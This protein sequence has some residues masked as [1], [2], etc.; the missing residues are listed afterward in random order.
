MTER[1]GLKKTDHRKKNESRW[2]HRIDGGV[3]RLRQEVNFLER[4]VKGDLGL[5]KKRVK[6]YRVERKELKTATE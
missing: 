3:K 5:K 6:R 2:R 1:I 4:E